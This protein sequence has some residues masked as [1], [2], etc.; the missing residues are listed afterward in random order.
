MKFFFL[1]T[2]RSSALL[3]SLIFG[4]DSLGFGNEAIGKKPHFKNEAVKHLQEK[5]LQ[6]KDLQGLRQLTK[7]LRKLEQ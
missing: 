5:S 7:N 1:Q 6:G 2:L 4:F 3:T